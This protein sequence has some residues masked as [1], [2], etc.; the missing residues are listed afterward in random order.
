MPSV[1]AVDRVVEHAA[2]LGSPA[3]WR[4]PE[5]QSDVVLA[6]I[7]AVWSIGVRAGGVANVIARYVELRGDAQHSFAELVAF[8][9]DL[10]GPDAFADAVRNR[11]RTSTTNGILK[12][13][14]IYLQARMLASA[15][16]VDVT[17]LT[18][19]VR[20]RWITVP[21]SRSGTSWD[22]FLLVLGED[23][24]KADRMLR[25]FCAKALRTTE[26]RVSAKRAHELVVAAAAQMGVT[27]R[28]LDGAIWAHESRG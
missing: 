2:V 28:A 19:D 9:D 27:A 10:G 15:G 4:R 1:T 25:R 17:G 20:A 5:P 12:A 26:S 11:Q 24:V 14:A 18:D 6:M 16:V 21:G 22:A 23:T 3:T 7:D 13:E 8:I